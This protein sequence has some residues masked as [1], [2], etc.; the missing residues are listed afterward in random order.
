MT[1]QEVRE[2]D[3]WINDFVPPPEVQDAISRVRAL[4]LHIKV[5][6]TKL[7]AVIDEQ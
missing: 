6:E 2:H 1:R 4:E 3:E 7:E 5:L